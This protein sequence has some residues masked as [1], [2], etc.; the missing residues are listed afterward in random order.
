MDMS[1][2]LAYFEFINYRNRTLVELSYDI[3]RNFFPVRFQVVDMVSK[4]S[5]MS[6][7]PDISC[8]ILAFQLY[9]MVFCLHIY[10]LIHRFD[11]DILAE[12]HRRAQV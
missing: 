3:N 8:L 10:I 1:N 7:F 2:I 4:I 6:N 12:T 5:P 9:L 11:P